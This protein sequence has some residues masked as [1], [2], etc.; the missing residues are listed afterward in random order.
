MTPTELTAIFSQ[1]QTDKSKYA[2]FYSFWLSQRDFSTI[3]EIGAYKGGGIRSLRHLFPQASVFGIESD[4]KL[5]QESPELDISVGD[6]ADTT[7]LDQ[8]IAH[9]ATQTQNQ[10]DLIIDDGGHTMHQQITSFQH[11]FPKLK[12]GGYYVVEDVETSYLSRWIDRKPT[13]VEFFKSTLDELNY[14]GKSHQ[15]EYG[16]SDLEHRNIPIPLMARFTDSI[17]FGNNIVLLI[18]K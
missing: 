11:L 18:R 4:R 1:Y 9:I 3:L 16:I 10:V 7:F 12:S 6:Q 13:T 5:A 17:H 2:R 14:H 8:T 15:G